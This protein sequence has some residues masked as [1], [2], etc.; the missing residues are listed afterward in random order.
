MALA[1]RRTSDAGARI[2]S[3]SRRERRGGRRRGWEGG[4]ASRARTAVAH[5][6]YTIV[7]SRKPITTK[8]GL[9][10]VIAAPGVTARAVIATVGFAIGQVFARLADTIAAD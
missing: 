10:R 4:N 7:G 5:V 3:W 9:A 6:F 8:V 1:L 2:G